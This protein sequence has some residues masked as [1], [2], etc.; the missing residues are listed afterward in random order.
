ML[1][2]L[3]PSWF[4]VI[5]PS[6]TLTHNQANIG[7]MS[8]ML[9]HSRHNNIARTRVGVCYCKIDNDDTCESSVVTMTAKPKGSSCLLKS[10]QLL[11][12]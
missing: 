11:S 3:A 5:P 10:K 12:F 1:E 6:S 4:N 9:I 7:L 8:R 2:L